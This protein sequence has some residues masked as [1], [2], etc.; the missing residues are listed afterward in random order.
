MSIFENINAFPWKKK[1]KVNEV[2]EAYKI[3]RKHR[4]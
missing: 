3:V 1:L 4:A 2:W